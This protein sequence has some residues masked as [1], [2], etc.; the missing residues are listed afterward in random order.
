MPEGFIFDNN[1]CVNCGACTASCIL[2]NEWTFRP[3]LIY[4]YNAEVMV[5]MPVINISLACNHCKEPACLKG[6]PA[7]A[8]YRDTLTGAVLIDDHK[9][10]GC[11]YCQ[12]N[13]PYDAPKFQNENKV[14]GKCNLCYAALSEGRLPSCALACPT[15]ALSYGVL[16]ES[17]LKKIP[18]WFPDKN[19]VPSLEFVGN[20]NV[21]P[22][23]I[24]PEPSFETDSDL[25]KIN[26]K[27]ITEDLS[28]VGFS[29][30]TTL[31]VSILISSVINGKFPHL[32]LFIAIT[33]LA[34]FISIFHTG[35]K[36]RVWRSLSN[37]KTS[38]LSREIA[39]FIIYS[40]V[41]SVAVFY[42]LPALLIASSA[43][44]LGLLI[45]IDSVYIYS[46]RSRP[47]IAHS[48]QTFLS[49][50]LIISFLTGS[51]LPFIFIGSIKMISSIINLS[52]R[53]STDTGFWLRFF[54][55]ALLFITGTNLV[56]GISFID[57]VVV[58]FFLA[59]EFLDRILFYFDFKPLNINT[60]IQNNLIFN[61]YEKKRG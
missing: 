30:L 15:G 1:K 5:P 47:V 12:W 27:S 41:S 17:A 33:F 24:I 35:K 8:Y 46:D 4:T 13:C 45:L 44:G 32:F 10:I 6:C 49:S 40:S 18:V 50:L 26:D 48:G 20:Q 22:L 55:M 31:S 7:G 23:R 57:P 52:V 21:E 3:R 38:P 16:S 43:I 51:I 9:C 53:R 59:G 34:G 58:L 56:T 37:L 42:E 2:E 11:K 19:L 25:P 61:K 54:R 36:I 28:L 39:G 60:F 14:I 29:F